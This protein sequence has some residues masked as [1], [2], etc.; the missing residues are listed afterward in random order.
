MASE[1]VGAALVRV[2]EYGLS[3]DNDWTID[4]MFLQSL[5]LLK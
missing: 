2:V 1:G 4:R 3:V 5:V